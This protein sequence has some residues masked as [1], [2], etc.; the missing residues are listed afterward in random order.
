MRIAILGTGIVGTTLGTAL[1]RGGHQVT[2]GAR[3][4]G[5]PKAAEWAAAAGP[6]AAAGSFADAAAAGDVV[7]N[8]TAGVA[9]LDALAAAGRASLAGK[10]LIDV[11]NPLDFSAGMPPSFTVCNTDSLGE[12]IQQAF[13]ETRVVK[14][15]NTIAAAL[16]VAP[17]QLPGP[18]HLFLCGDDDG[19]KA[20]VAA[21]LT[22]WFG[23]PP[24]SLVDVGPIAAAR[25]TEMFLAF[26]LRLMLTLGTVHFSVGLALTPETAATVAGRAAAAQQA[27]RRAQATSPAP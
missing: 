11:A 4:R 21:W 23:W 12:R 9:S 7:F 27:A 14:A 15:L 5:N 13:P 16:M 17:A 18:H 22:D 2:L 25:G 8:C 26:W 19:A 6:G 3:E 10:I 24:E 1:V 20:R